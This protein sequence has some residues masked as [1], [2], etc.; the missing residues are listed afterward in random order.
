M[1]NNRERSTQGPGWPEVI[2][3]G[4]FDQRVVFLSGELDHESAGRLAAQL[5]TLDAT[6]QE[7]VS[8]YID[9]GGGTLEA[10]F[11]IIDIID[12]LGVPVHATCVGRAEGPAL[13]VLAVANK[14][15]VTPHARLR[16]CEP[17]A[18]FEGTGRDIQAWTQHRAGQVQRF[19][20]RLAEATGQPG[21]HVE[22]DMSAGRFFDAEQACQ[23]GLADEVL[24]PGAVVRR[25]PTPPPTIG[26]S[27][28]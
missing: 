10:A 25:F 8:L 9:S 22:A 7:V 17:K 2:G 24:R 20:A 21:E 6:D 26:F 23:Y 15:M 16:L 4:L 5:M 19:V 13:G 14:R 28:R 27:L 18:F 1:T 3:A 11:T 12:L